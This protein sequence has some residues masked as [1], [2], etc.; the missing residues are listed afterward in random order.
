MFSTTIG[1]PR[2]PRMCSAMTREGASTPP[3][4]DNATTS[5][6]GRDGKLCAGACAPANSTAMPSARS[7]RLIVHSLL[8]LLDARGPNDRPPFLDVGLLLRDQRVRRLPVAR[9]DFHA[10][11]GQ[12]LAYRRIGERLHHRGVEPGDDRLRRAGR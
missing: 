8:L 6:I 5:V 12:T 4:A 10:E 7:S 9:R 11:P 3:P 1:W 2:V